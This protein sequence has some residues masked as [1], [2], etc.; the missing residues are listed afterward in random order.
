MYSKNEYKGIINLLCNLNKKL[1]VLSELNSGSFSI[2]K[3]T[4]TQKVEREGT[5][6]DKYLKNN[7]NEIFPSLHPSSAIQSKNTQKNQA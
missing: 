3:S 4:I 5:L 7:V 2:I 1:P 6:T